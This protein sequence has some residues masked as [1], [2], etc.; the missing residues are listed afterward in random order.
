MNFY[1]L[2]YDR[3]SVYEIPDNTTLSAVAQELMIKI[4]EIQE[5]P[6]V[7]IPGTMKPKD[8]T[9]SILT[10]NNSR[11]ILAEILERSNFFKDSTLTPI[12]LWNPSIVYF[13]NRFLLCWRDG[14]KVAF[15]WLSSNGKSM[16]TKSYLGIGGND[17][18]KHPI[19]SGPS[20]EQEDPR[21]FV[22][23]NNKLIV[24]FTGFFPDPKRPHVRIGKNIQ[25][26]ITAEYSSM[27]QKLIFESNITQFDQQ[28]D[29]PRQ[30]IGF[31]LNMRILYILFKIYKK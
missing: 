10:S 5:V 9:P 2:Y 21:L 18:I 1:L 15:G 8:K 19:N 6:R 25:C 28:F 7:F 30:K 23:S 11:I 14:G 3:K 22:L 31:H 27:T 29:S 16:D 4:N 13:Q 20:I 24:S 26:F 12:P 17:G